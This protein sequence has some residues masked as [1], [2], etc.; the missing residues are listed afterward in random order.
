M[1]KTLRFGSQAV[2]AKIKRR[3]TMV[4]VTKADEDAR[5]YSVSGNTIHDAEIC[6]ESTLA[7]AA[8]TIDGGEAQHLV[9]AGLHFCTGCKGVGAAT[10]APAPEAVKPVEEPKPV[11]KASSRAALGRASARSKK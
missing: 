5:R 8:E 3:T 10:S 7:S 6:D 2:S 9:A 1:Q 11:P 4:A